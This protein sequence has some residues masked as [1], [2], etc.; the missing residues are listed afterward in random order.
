MLP[1]ILKYWYHKIV[2]LVNVEVG[3]IQFNLFFKWLVFT[4]ITVAKRG[5]K[6]ETA[7]VIG[8][9]IEPTRHQSSRGPTVDHSQPVELTTNQLWKNMIRIKLIISIYSHASR[10]LSTT[11]LTYSYYF[12]TKL[13]QFQQVLWEVEVVLQSNLVL[14][15]RLLLSSNIRDMNNEGIC[16]FSGAD[17]AYFVDY[18]RHELGLTAYIVRSQLFI[19]SLIYLYSW[20]IW[21][22][23]VVRLISL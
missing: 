15:G 14:S 4:S 1:V 16:H 17:N 10:L 11:G 9:Q 8:I 5:Q 3:W 12:V 23:T 22:R 19:I 20:N 6:T 2:F 13:F 21:H 18:K 7:L